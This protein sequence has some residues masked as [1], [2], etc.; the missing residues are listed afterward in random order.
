MYITQRKQRDSAI[1]GRVMVKERENSM[2]KKV[3]CAFLCMVM[4]ASMLAGCGGNSGSGNQSNS[5]GKAKIDIFQNKSEFAAELEVAAQQYMDENPDVTIHIETV[6]G[7]EYNTSLKAK[8]LNDDQPE[9]FGGG[10]ANI[11]EDYKDYVEDLSGEPWVEHIREEYREY[12][13]FDGKVLGLPL[14]VEGYG[15]VYNTEI[16]ETAGIDASKLTTYDA[17]D[18]A[19]ADLQDQIDSGK[20]ADQYPVLE[21]VEEY[22]AKETFIPGIHMTNVAL[23]AELESAQGA[24]NAQEIEFTYADAFKDL[25][26]L[27][28]KY[29]PA[30]ENLS[31]LNS[32][33]YSSEIG[34]GLGIERIAVVQQGNW[35]APEMENVAPEIAD[36]L[37]ILPI[38]L[39]GVVEDSIATGVSFNWCVNKTS[40]DVDKQAAKDFLN[41]LFQSEDGKRIVVEELGCI[42][43]FD[44]YDGL[45]QN[46]AL[47]QAVVRYIEEGK[48]MPWVFSGYPNGYEARA[49]ASVQGYFAGDMTWEQ[50]IDTM[51]TDWKELRSSS[52]GAAE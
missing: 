52:A 11:L 1:Q 20:L 9:I 40:S 28:T 24:Y 8:F 35:I 39:K 27:E 44:N 17:I 2:K 18:E 5:E 48:T 15:L 23:Q 12:V 7:S 42:P 37:D 21:A 14:S 45:E 13:T 16:F 32:V 41:W 47:S 10:M 38:P 3:I 22:A 46:N 29:T 6:Q 50:C 26:E 49:A 30:K 34:G 31:L 51:K 33:D 19:F 25:V 4:T 43:A 36:K